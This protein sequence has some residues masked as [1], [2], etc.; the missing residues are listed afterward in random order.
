[1]TF[2]QFLKGLAPRRHEWDDLTPEQVRV[3]LLALG[4][5]AICAAVLFI[6]ERRYGWFR[7]E[8]SEPLDRE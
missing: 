2:V 1:M 8:K 5:I 4:L 6:L 7:T 3:R